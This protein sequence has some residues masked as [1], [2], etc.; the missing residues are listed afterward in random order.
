MPNPRPAALPHPNPRTEASRRNGAK[1][2]GPET[3]EGK[4]GS[5][6]NALKHGLC[7]E[8]FVA[9]GEEDQAAF[10]A[11]EATLV[12]ELVPEGR[13]TAARGPDRAGRLRR[14]ARS[15]PRKCQTNPRPAPILASWR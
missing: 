5:A 9:L 12:E 15:P 11:L 13:T 3:R 1:S 6:Q 10:D 2:R 8:T 7:A 4:A 14:V